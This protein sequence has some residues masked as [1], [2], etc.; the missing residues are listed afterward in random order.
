[1][2][3]PN[4]TAPTAVAW[5]AVASATSQTPTN[6]LLRVALFAVGGWW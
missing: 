6:A 3:V 2:V 5:L 1:M 4:R